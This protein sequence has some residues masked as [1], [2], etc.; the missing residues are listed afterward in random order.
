MAA[1]KLLVTCVPQI[2]HGSYGAILPMSL[3]R[4]LRNASQLLT[5]PSPRRGRQPR[6]KAFS[7]AFSRELQTVNASVRMFTESLEHRILPASLA[8]V[9]DIN[10]LFQTEVSGNTNWDTNTLPASGDQL[11]FPDIAGDRSLTNDSSN[12]SAYTLDFSSAGYT[13]AGNTIALTAT[14]TDLR[15]TTGSTTIQTPLT[16]APDTT[17]DISAGTTTL[18]GSL[19]GSGGFTKSGSG[20]LLITATGDFTGNATVNAGTLNLQ[21]NL[22]GGGN[23]DITSTATFTGNGTFSGP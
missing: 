15:S 16:L 13:V 22:T 11:T 14:G 8:W 5:E 19:S 7:R 6:R 2:C 4:F 21:G 23:L 17:I 10:P 3:S 18:A 20:E 1:A 12:G 9:G